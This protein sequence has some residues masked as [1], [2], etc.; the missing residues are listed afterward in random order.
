MVQRAA[1]YVRLPS[2]LT[3][4]IDARTQATGRTK[5]AVVEELLTSAI[6][7]PPAPQASED[8]VDLTAIAT[9]LDVTEQ[10][11][12]DRVADGDFPA[13]RIGGKWRFSV[14]AVRTWLAGTDPVHP[15]VTG[16]ASNH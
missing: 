13:R 3:S 15:R 2:A 7:E 16:F 5:Q 10:D 1:L 9:L 4:A 6:D 12:L 14:A 11:V 8:V